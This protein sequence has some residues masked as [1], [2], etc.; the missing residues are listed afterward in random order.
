MAY[1]SLKSAVSN[2]ITDNGNNEI[3]GPILEALINDN[4]IPQLGSNLYKGVATPSTNPG[5]PENEIFYI[6]A[7]SG[8]YANFSGIILTD[9]LAAIKNVNGA[10][11]K[12][13]LLD[14]NIFTGGY[15]GTLQ[16]LKDE[17]AE[18]LVRDINFESVGLVGDST[19]EWQT[20]LQSGSGAINIEKEEDPYFGNIL[21]LTLGANTRIRLAQ[22]LEYPVKDYPLNVSYGFYYKGNATPISMRM[23]EGANI[24]HQTFVPVSLKDGWLFE[25]INNKTIDSGLS[26]PIRFDID[27]NNNTGSDYAY[28]FAT[29][30]IIQSP[31][32][33]PIRYKYSNRTSVELRKLKETLQNRIERLDVDA[34]ID[35]GNEVVNGEFEMGYYRHSIGS[36]GTFAANTEIVEE[37]N[38]YGFK[39]LRYDN[40]KRSS[41][42]VASVTRN[43]YKFLIPEENRGGKVSFSFLVKGDQN[44]LTIDSDC[45]VY[46]SSDSYLGLITGTKLK[47]Y[48]QGEDFFIQ[49]QYNIQLPSGAVY[50]QLSCRA[51]T[52]ATA[53]LDTIYPSYFTGLMCE[54]VDSKVYYKRK[55]SDDLKRVV[56]GN[57]KGK[58]WASYGDSIT[59]FYQYQLYVIDQFKLFHYLRGIGGSKVTQDNTT[60]YVDA[61]GNYISQ[62]PSTPSGV[63][64][65]DYF[66]INRSMC[67]PERISTIP[68][69]T[70]IITVMAGTN[71]SQVTLGSIN[72]TVNNTFYGA[73]QL[74]IDE[75]QTQLP[76]AE[77]ILITP[78]HKVSEESDNSL[79]PK[80]E[81]IREIAKKYKLRLID[82]G[83]CGINKNN[84][85]VMLPDGTH[86][87]IEGYE[88]M[89]RIIIK[90]FNF[91]FR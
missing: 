22:W 28:Y 10:W 23:T 12:D 77:L 84:S 13:T 16:D 56:F 73:Y 26:N 66:E 39:A 70:E 43:R 86:P 32:I 62:P 69:D 24:L 33:Y 47:E 45:E 6:A 87:S 59:E 17:T 2:V 8:S 51:T 36:A 78:I 72:D 76:T 35:Y 18:N 14:F 31:K 37:V 57:L 9:E 61:E 67:S 60:A 21:K 40:L 54:F 80:R 82:M 74:M 50:L 48:I 91:I 42:N 49:H 64:G 71:D 88:R 75:I 1:E 83:E 53:A 3:T 79:E 20:I 15:V 44:N 81:A 38:P 52:K 55:A 5:T 58:K 27:I 7:Q 63:L 85:S 41:D 65:V 89:A 25:S 46:D 34:I 4:L 68:S 11:V 19:T 90:E 29:P 30:A